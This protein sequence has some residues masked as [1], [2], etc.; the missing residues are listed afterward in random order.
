MLAVIAPGTYSNV[1]PT[2]MIEEATAHSKME[3]QRSER[4][5]KSSS[6]R[7]SGGES[8]YPR[9]GS[10]GGGRGGGDKSKDKDKSGS[11]TSKGGGAKGGGPR[12]QG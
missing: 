10:K 7:G 4:V 2:W 9:G 11:R 12:T 6:G 5:H 1:A 8:S 3:H